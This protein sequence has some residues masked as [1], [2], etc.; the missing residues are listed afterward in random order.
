MR[1]DLRHFGTGRISK[2]KQ[3]YIMLRMISLG[4]TART[5]TSLH[6]L[7]VLI[8]REI[9]R[10]VSLHAQEAKGGEEEK[11]ALHL[12]LLLV[13]FYHSKS[14]LVICQA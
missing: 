10:A 8:K 1:C 13:G 9:W 4:I 14:L 3:F 11:S 6:L 5:F 2:K 7:A 12:C